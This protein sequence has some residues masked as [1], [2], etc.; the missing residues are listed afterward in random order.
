MY[1]VLAD[2]VVVVHFA[3]LLFVVFGGFLAWRWRWVIWPHVVAAGW[4]A[5]IITLGVNCPL[6]HVENGLRRRAGQA[7]LAGGFIDT[8]VQGVLYPER[9]VGLARG[10][11]VLVVLLSWAGLVLRARSAATRAPA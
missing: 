3:F 6:T 9:L 1:A 11:V 2:V 8:Y 10:L 7:E 4:G 5:V